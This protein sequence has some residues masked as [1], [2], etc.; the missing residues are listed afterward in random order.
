MPVL[1]LEQAPC[2][3]VSPNSPIF[4]QL[5]EV[6]PKVLRAEAEIPGLAVSGLPALTLQFVKVLKEQGCRAL[7]K[8]E[9][10]ADAA[11]FCEGTHGR[12]A[13]KSGAAFCPVSCNCT[14]LLPG[15]PF[16][17]PDSLQSDNY[18]NT[19]PPTTQQI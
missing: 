16:T 7:L 2:I 1:Q 11:H 19:A 6:L 13:Q 5:E 8:E 17:C 4:G 10:S 12:V 9:F 15:C 14:N 3:D 18:T